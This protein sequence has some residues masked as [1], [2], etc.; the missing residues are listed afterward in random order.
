MSDE[1]NREII[2]SMSKVMRTMKHSISINQRHPQV[3][4]HQFEAL[5]CIKKSKHA[6][7]SEIA[8]HFSTTMPTATS[9][10][11]KLIA[12]KLARRKNDN[13]DRR[14]VKISLTGRGEKMLSEVA[15]QRENKI[16]KL[17]SYLSEKDKRDLLRIL[18]TIDKKAEE[19][20]K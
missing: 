16:N 4:M 13:T 8:Q 15:T 10:V 17:L 6:H 14:I 3:T 2:D 1:L 18:Q 19:Y 20:E 7:M 9:L 11:D 5:W 12:S